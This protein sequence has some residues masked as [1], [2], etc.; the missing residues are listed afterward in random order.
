M[1]QGERVELDSS[2]QPT[3][4]PEVCFPLTNH[5]TDE[6]GIAITTH[7]LHRDRYTSANEF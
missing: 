3:I 6:R 2:N 4:Q 1:Q 7:S 5:S